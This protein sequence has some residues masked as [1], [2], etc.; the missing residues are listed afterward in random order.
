V[1]LIA[2]GFALWHPAL[3]R[4]ESGRLAV[5]AGL[6]QFR[7]HLGGDLTLA[8]PAGLGRRADVHVFDHHAFAE[9]H[10]RLKTW[11]EQGTAIAGSG[12]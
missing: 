8:M 12:S 10:A 5:L 1:A 3:E 9:A 4:R 6:E 11:V 2:M 7:E